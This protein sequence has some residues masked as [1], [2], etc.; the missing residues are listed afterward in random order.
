MASPLYATDERVVMTMDA[1][2]S[3]LRFSAAG[4]SPCGPLLTNP[5]F[6]TAS[7][8]NMLRIVGLRQL[9]DSR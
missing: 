3:S 1:G 8:I 2:G 4:K 5:D 7:F 9:L 6:I